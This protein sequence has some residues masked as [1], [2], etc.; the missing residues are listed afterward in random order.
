[1]RLKIETFAGISIGVEG[2]TEDRPECLSSMERR[3]GFLV[4]LGAAGFSPSFVIAELGA[5]FGVA[6]YASSYFAPAAV[7][8]ESSVSW[9]F[10]WRICFSIV[11]RTL[12]I[13]VQMCGSTLMMW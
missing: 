1:M 9:I 6:K 7:F 5:A 11:G 12:S 2:N 3:Y 13:G 10:F 8:I 4:G